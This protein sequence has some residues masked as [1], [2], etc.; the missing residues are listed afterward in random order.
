MMF[1]IVLLVDSGELDQLLFFEARVS[2]AAMKATVKNVVFQTLYVVIAIM[3][4]RTGRM[5]GAVSLVK[6]MKEESE[7]VKD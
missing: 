3:I 5:T 4:T 7:Q 1:W 2:H 6:V